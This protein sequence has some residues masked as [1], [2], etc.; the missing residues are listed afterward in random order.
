[1]ILRIEITVLLL[2][3]M[4]LAACSGGQG[5]PPK[6]AASAQ[7]VTVKST[8]QMR[9]EPATLTVRA[10]SPVSLTLDNSGA[11]LAHDFVVDS[12]GGQ[13]VEVKAPPNG[14]GTVQFTP[15]AAGTYQ[16][17]CAEPCHKEAGMVGTLTVS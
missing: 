5:A 4:T 12:V 9:F 11:A 10:N 7:N 2:G 16:F 15:T 6:P 17:Y 13:K 1:M 14:K 3:A 8:D